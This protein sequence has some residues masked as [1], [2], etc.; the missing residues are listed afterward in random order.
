MPATYNKYIMIILFRRMAAFLEHITNTQA[1][2]S[3]SL[4]SVVG[5]GNTDVVNLE[6]SST[7]DAS[8]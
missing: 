1:K 5:T 3:Q 6:I 4:N 2:K 7:Q 8:V